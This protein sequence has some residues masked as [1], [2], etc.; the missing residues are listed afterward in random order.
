VQRE[1]RDYAGAERTL[2]NLLSR[3]P[4]FVYWLE[5]GQVKLVHY[6]W[7][8][9]VAAVLV[10]LSSRYRRSRRELH[11]GADGKKA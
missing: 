2:K 11:G 3:A 1:V 4:N 6:Y 9:L 8:L 7:L 5:W 10:Y